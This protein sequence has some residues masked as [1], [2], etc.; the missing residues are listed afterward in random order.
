MVVKVLLGSDFM[1]KIHVH[2]SSAHQPFIW[3]KIPLYCKIHCPKQGGK[4]AVWN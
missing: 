3:S 1:H 2:Y 4:V